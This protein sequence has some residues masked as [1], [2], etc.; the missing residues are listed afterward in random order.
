[1]DE[2]DNYPMYDTLEDWEDLIFG[3]NLEKIETDWW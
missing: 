3:L 2:M 1:L